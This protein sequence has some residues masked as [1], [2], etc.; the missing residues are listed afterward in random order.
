VSLII[1][2]IIIIIIMHHHHHHASSSSF[3]IIVSVP[4]CALDRAHDTSDSRT[5][6]DKSVVFDT[7]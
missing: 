6:S 3:I 7:T 5:A 1:I 4:K 2:I